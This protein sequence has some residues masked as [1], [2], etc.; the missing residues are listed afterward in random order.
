MSARIE[1]PGQSVNWLYD[2]VFDV[3]DEPLAKNV[4]AW[5]NERAYP[6]GLMHFF[7]LFGSEYI[8][9]TDHEGL[10]EVL[11]T[12]SYDFEKSRAFR[13]YS[14]RFFGDSL[15]TQEQ[16][17]HNRNRKTFMPVF[18]QTNINAVRPPLTSKSRQFNDYISSLL[19]MSGESQRSSEG[20]GT[21]VVPVTDVVF[22]ATMDTGSILALGI[23]L[24]TIKGRN[25][26]ILQAFKTLFASNRQKKIR[27][28]L[29]NLL[30]GWLDQLVPSTEA[31]DMDRARILLVES[32]VNMMQGKLAKNERTG[33]HLT[34]L[35]NLEQSGPFNHDEYIGQLR[36]I[37]AAGFESSGGSLSFVIYCLA[38]NRDAQQSVREELRNAKRGR[39]EL[40]ETRQPI[41]IHALE[42]FLTQALPQIRPPFHVQQFQV[43][44]SN[45]TYKITDS[46]GIA[47][48]LRKKPPGKLLSRTVHQIE[49]EYRALSAFQGTEVP[50]PKTYCLYEKDDVLGTPFYVMEFL[51]GRIF[52][53]FTMPGVSPT[54]RIAL[55]RDAVRVLG[56]IH[57]TNYHSVGLQRFG[58]QGG[59]YDRQLSTFTYLSRAQGKVED[60]LTKVPVGE[61]PHYTEMVDFFC[62]HEP[63]PKDRHTIVHG[64]YKIDNLIFYPTESRVIG[65]LDWEMATMGH[66]L[67][68]FCN[69]THPYFWDGLNQ[70][71]AMF[72]D[73][74]IIVA[75]GG[76]FGKELYE[77][78]CEE[79]LMRYGKEGLKIRSIW[80]AD[81]AHQAESN[82][83]NGGRLG[84]DPSH[85][86][87]S[88][89]LLHLINVKRDD[90]PRP[91]V[92]IGHSAGC[93]SVVHLSLMHPRLFHAMVLFE[94]P[95]F[96]VYRRE[97][98]PSRPAATESLKRKPFYQAWDRRVFAQFVKY[99]LRDVLAKS[100][101]S[102]ENGRPNET[103]PVRLTTPL[104]QELASFAR[105]YHN[106][107]APDVGVGDPRNRLTHPDLDPEA[108]TSLPFYRPEITELFPRLP[109]LRPSVL[110]IFGSESHMSLPELRSDKLRTTGIA[111]GG[112]GGAAAGR[113]REVVMQGFSHQV[114]FEAVDECAE[115]ISR[116]LACESRRWHREEQALHDRWGTLH[117]SDQMT[118]DKDWKA[119]IRRGHRVKSNL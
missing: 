95:I 2:R 91:I 49:R 66:P 18:N 59:Y 52:T 68:D 100:E 72:R 96:S 33:D 74:T 50:V 86:D 23:D 64:D 58:K 17:V 26:H 40:D 97:A 114:P 37:I 82:I 15:V 107:P 80:A 71:V 63:R 1:A 118:I 20:R 70:D 5:V 109:Y 48:V 57:T 103:T 94:A 65:V 76:G 69:L 41:D 117:V 77:P 102:D 25:T 87:H 6:G 61:L 45:P 8:V 73:A 43:G 10:V 83:I 54:E 88:R 46:G 47:Y 113:V 42:K 105:P 55:W 14:V 98:W 111:T 92:A 35:S 84:I 4:T 28:I 11:S 31:K 90:M 67:S 9:P 19:K 22:R 27:F 79:L 75:P 62:R 101:I 30:P 44:Q 13:R 119:H 38:A 89:D 116:W 53:D 99:G 60:P 36:T 110:Y 108:L 34:Y 21:A 56:K 85:I 29:H 106:L 115:E 51:D 3:F 16:E 12:R 32:V 78:V 93:L 112:S 81:P 39:M 104:V 24:E 7:G